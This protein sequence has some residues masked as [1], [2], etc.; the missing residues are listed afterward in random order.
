DDAAISAFST[1]LK[2]HLAQGAE[3]ISIEQSQQNLRSAFD[4]G[5]SFLR[6]AAL[7]AAL[8]SGIAVALTAQRYAR[9]KTDEVALLRCLGASRGEILGALTIEIAMLALPACLLGLCL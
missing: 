7:L 4:R 2:S 6:L 8:L 5:E 1:F 9:R 3:L